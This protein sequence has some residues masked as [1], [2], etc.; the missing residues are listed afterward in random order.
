MLNKVEGVGGAATKA[1]VE[2]TRGAGV[3]GWHGIA[4]KRCP[5]NF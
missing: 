2:Q 3:V 4:A 1:L 5:R